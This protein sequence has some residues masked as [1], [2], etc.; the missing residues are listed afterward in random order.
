MVLRNKLF[1]K[2]VWRGPPRS[3][4]HKM[5]NITANVT[6]RLKLGPNG[7]CVQTG[8]YNTLTNSTK[9][10]MQFEIANVNIAKSIFMV[11]TGRACHH[12]TPTIVLFSLAWLS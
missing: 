6:I 3:I 1:T 11:V 8:T 10:S 12:D 2:A 5:K 9:Y 4:L 7:G